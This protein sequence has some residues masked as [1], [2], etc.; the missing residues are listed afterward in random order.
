MS[1]L[2]YFAIGVAVVIVIPV[3]LWAVLYTADHVAGFDRHFH[4]QFQEIKQGM[5]ETEVLHLLGDP[6]ER[7]RRFRLGQYEGFEEEYSAAEASGATHYLVW[8]NGVDVVYSVGF[9]QSGRV[10]H[11]ACGGT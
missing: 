7:S 11:S 4:R 10:V 9:D 1:R 6:V 5:T 8:V 3:G 2:H